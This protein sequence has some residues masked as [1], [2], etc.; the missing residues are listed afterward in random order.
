MAY[1]ASPAAHPKVVVGTGYTSNNLYGTG[2][3]TV[4][5]SAKTLV[6]APDMA[7]NTTNV[8]AER[9]YVVVA[10][11]VVLKMVGIPMPTGGA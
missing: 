8:L 9:A 11:C 5:R 4:Y 7:N 1:A 10:D 6:P 2:D 3:V